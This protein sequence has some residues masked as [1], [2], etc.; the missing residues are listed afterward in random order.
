MQ[1]YL[2]KEVEWVFK[3]E[4]G[5]ETKIGLKPFTGGY[6]PRI[7]E[8]HDKFREGFDKNGGDVNNVSVDAETL[9][10]LYKLLFD[11]LDMNISGDSSSGV[12][13]DE[14]L[15]TFLDMHLN[16]VFIAFFKIHGLDKKTMKDEM[17]E[18]V[19][20]LAARRPVKDRNR[21]GGIVE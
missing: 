11:W 7:L 5:L 21:P 19:G 6:L 2:G 12:S 17:I 16:D 8:I 9:E 4:D 10:K 1:A 3:R 14:V 18:E 20:E 15:R 13:R